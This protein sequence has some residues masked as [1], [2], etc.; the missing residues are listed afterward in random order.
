MSKQFWGSD[1][2]LIED[3]A[4]ELAKIWLAG[5]DLTAKTPEQVKE[6]FVDAMQ[7]IH[8]HNVERWD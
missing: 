2:N 8:A 6:M 3:E 7:R 4:C 1:G 5:Q